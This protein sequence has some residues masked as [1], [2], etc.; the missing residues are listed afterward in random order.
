[1]R[2]KAGGGRGAA[3]QRVHQ[4]FDAVLRPHRTG[5]RPPSLV[6]LTHSRTAELDRGRA[7]WALQCAHVTDGRRQQSTTGRCQPWE[8]LNNAGSRRGGVHHLTA[9]GDVSVGLG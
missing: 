7:A 2:T 1:M 3:G 6:R 8:G 9:A 5:R 4:E